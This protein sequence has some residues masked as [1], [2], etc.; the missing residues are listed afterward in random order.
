MILLAFITP[1][2]LFSFTPLFLLQAIGLE[3]DR[4][5]ILEPSIRCGGSS[6]EEVLEEENIAY[7]AYTRPKRALYL[8]RSARR[9]SLFDASWAG[10]EKEVAARNLETVLSQMMEPTPSAEIMADESALVAYFCTRANDVLGGKGGKRGEDAAF[11][12]L[13]AALR[14]LGEVMPGDGNGGGVSDVKE[15]AVAVRLACRRLFLVTHPDKSKG[16]PPADAAARQA[17]CRHL[18][19]LKEACGLDRRRQ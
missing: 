10:G 7:V 12:A 5:F 18:L 8:L 11:S 4:V 17:V 14:N 3:W 2:F 9:G 6:R 1:C 15:E 16:L 13:K 19:D